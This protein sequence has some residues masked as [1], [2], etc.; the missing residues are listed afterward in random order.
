MSPLQLCQNEFRT[1][2]KPLGY[3]Q[4]G[5]NWYSVNELG[6]IKVISYNLSSVAIDDFL[7]GVEYSI[8]FIGVQAMVYNRPYE[9][10]K[11][12]EVGLIKSSL[13]LFRQKKSFEFLPN[14]PTSSL[15]DYARDRISGE[16]IPFL[17]KFDKG[18]DIA[19]FLEEN[20][21]QFV[22]SD[23]ILVLSLAALH[24]HLGNKQRGIELAKKIISQS[25]VPFPFAED[26]FSRIS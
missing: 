16:A 23:S 12:L 25:K 7:F 9:L 11:C 14:T 10:K 24:V 26:F 17:S 21:E 1:I 22:N 19:I 20:L 8:N 15:I 5:K 13:N 18:A 6:V 3:K 4:Q 2:L